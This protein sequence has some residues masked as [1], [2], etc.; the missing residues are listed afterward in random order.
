MTVQNLGETGNL[1]QLADL[2]GRPHPRNLAHNCTPDGARAWGKKR[3]FRLIHSQP[4]DAA[5][6]GMS[7]GLAFCK[8]KA[9]NLA[10][11]RKVAIW[12]VSSDQLQFPGR[13]PMITDPASAI[14]REVLQLIDL[15]IETLRRD[16][17]LN[18][19]ELRDYKA[20]SEKI[21]TLYGELDRIGRTR[22][23]FKFPRAS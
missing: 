17:S 20:R 11:R 5:Q 1:Q 14:K 16:S 19:S 15:Q 8:A 3:S 4:A 10:I 6:I 7:A 12:A 23:A 18:W 9:Q 2:E 21:R 22:V 13:I